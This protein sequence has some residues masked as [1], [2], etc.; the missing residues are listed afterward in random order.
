MLAAYSRKF[1]D[2]KTRAMDLIREVKAGKRELYTPSTLMDI[3]TSWKIEYLRKKIKK[4]FAVY[5]TEIVSA[6]R[7]NKIASNIGIDANILKDKFVE[8]G[9]KEEDSFLVI[10]A[11]LLDLELKTFNKKHLISKRTEINKILKE[12]NLNEISISEP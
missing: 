9:I 1:D 7:I 2:K 6:E 4:F 11:S 8:I 10:I 3:V 5:S 12:S